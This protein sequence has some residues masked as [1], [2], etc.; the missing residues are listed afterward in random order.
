[1]IATISEKSLHVAGGDNGTIL[2]RTGRFGLKAHVD[3]EA[4]SDWFEGEDKMF[5]VGSEGRNQALAVGARALGIHHL[6]RSENKRSLL[7]KARWTQ[8]SEEGGSSDHEKDSTADEV[9]RRQPKRRRVL[10]KKVVVAAEGE[11]SELE[12]RDGALRG[13]SKKSGRDSLL[14]KSSNDNPNKKPGKK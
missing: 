12:V 3:R 9:Q 10:R 1:M 7:G 5:R 13:V 11:S 2:L 8:P 4:Q 6:G 14:L